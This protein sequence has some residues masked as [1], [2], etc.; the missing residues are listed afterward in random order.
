MGLHGCHPRHLDAEAAA[1]PGPAVQVDIG[2]EQDRDAA[3]DGQ[4]QA[5]PLPRCIL[6]A[7]EL[8]EDQSSASARIPGPVSWT[9]MRS[10]A[11]ASYNPAARCRLRC[12]GPRW[13]GNSAGRGAA[14][15]DRCAPRRG[16]ATQRNSQAALAREHA[17]LARQRIQHL[18]QRNTRAAA[19]VP[20]ASSRDMSSSA[21]EQV[22]SVESSAPRSAVTS[23]ALLAIGRDLLP[24]RP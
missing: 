1:A 2:T 5:K 16:W 10:A 19:P 3:G 8:L 23:F 18:G 12:S 13:P 21:A 15:A 4:A 6:A 11:M 20:P 24:R 9:S 14:V 17:E 7:A 22:G